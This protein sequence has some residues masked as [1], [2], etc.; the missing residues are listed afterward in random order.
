ML[1]GVQRNV[2]EAGGAEER[3]GKDECAHAGA[4]TQAGCHIDHHGPTV[5]RALA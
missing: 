3:Q 2:R 1:G 4:G 5:L